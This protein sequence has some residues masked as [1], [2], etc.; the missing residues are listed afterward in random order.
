MKETFNGVQIL[1]KY[2]K[3]IAFNWISL[4]RFQEYVKHIHAN[5]MGL[6]IFS[7]KLFFIL[8]GQLI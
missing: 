4:V 3:M 1:N 7:I 6:Q 5:N 2:P 8:N